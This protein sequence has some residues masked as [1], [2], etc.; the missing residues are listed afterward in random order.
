MKS[1]KGKVHTDLNMSARG[2]FRNGANAI[3]K[4][5][6]APQRAGAAGQNVLTLLFG[7]ILIVDSFIQWITHSG[8]RQYIC[9]KLNGYGSVMMA[10]AWNFAHITSSVCDWILL[11]WHNSY[12]QVGGSDREVHLVAHV[13]AHTS[14]HVHMQ[15]QTHT[16]VA[17]SNS[18]TLK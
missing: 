12:R 6:N 5:S 4:Q 1:V 18:F 3:W 16:H 10:Q 14:V 11:N 13:H 17:P 7:F 8:E 2:M 15:A 9:V